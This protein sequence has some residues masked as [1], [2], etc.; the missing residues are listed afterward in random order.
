MSIKETNVN[1]SESMGQLGHKLVN[2]TTKVFDQGEQIAVIVVTAGTATVTAKQHINNP[3]GLDWYDDWT[4]VILPV[5]TYVVNLK[6]VTIVATDL[7]IA[8]YG[9]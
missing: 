1:S 9:A 5:G 8:Y 6:E 2:A 3:K 4:T 7:V